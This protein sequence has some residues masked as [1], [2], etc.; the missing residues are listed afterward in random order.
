VDADASGTLTAADQPLAN[1]G[2]SLASAG[3]V[4]TATTDAAGVAVVRELDPASYRIEPTGTPPAGAVL[5]SNPSPTAAI[6]VRGDSITVEFRYVVLPGSVAGRIYRDDDA[7]GSFDAGSDTPGAGLTV[8]LRRD[9]G[10]AAGDTLATTTTDDEGAYAFTLLAPGTYFV[11]FENPGTIDYGAANAPQLVT[12]APRGTATADAVFTGSLLITIAEARSKAT[13]SPVAVVGAVIVPPGRFTSGSGGVNSEIWI[14]DASGGIAVFSVLTADSLTYPLGQRV[15][16]AGTLGAFSGQLQISSPTVT[17]ETGTQ[18]VAAKTITAA[19][20]RA[21]GDEGELVTVNGFEVLTVQGGTS[22]AF[23]VT[24]RDAAGDTL[25]VRVAG[26]ATGLARADFTVG[27]TYTVTGVL[28]RFQSGSN[29]PVA[30][31]KVRFPTDVVAQTAPTPG[32]IVINELMANPA[33]VL[34]NAGEYVELYNAGGSAVDLQGWEIRDNF[35]VDTIDVPLVVPAGGYVVLG[36][37]DDPTT[38]GGITVAFEYVS[39]IALGNSGDRFVIKDAS[40]ATVD[41]VAYTSGAQAA[42]GVAFGVVDP[43]QDN[44]DMGGANWAAQ[45]STYGGGDKGTPGAR[46]DG[47]AVPAIAP[48]AGPRL[49]TAAPRRKAVR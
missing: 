26:V 48:A 41:S 9:V 27:S 38:N 40:G 15:R 11:E 30:Q 22:A 8:Y 18:P 1:F 36:V 45:T 46:N 2:V 43:A 35:G 16:V 13:G 47:A 42:A 25:T 29:P 44:T 4:L 20:A 32:T 6:S 24:G 23:N 10:G 12:V 33:A 7:S 31:I 39:T 21:L 5:A 49:T 14:Q 37:N 28:T 34:D 19:Q 3:D 17:L